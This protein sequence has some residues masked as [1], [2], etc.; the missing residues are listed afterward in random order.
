MVHYQTECM[1]TVNKTEVDK[2]GLGD[3]EKNK[4]Q[5]VFD[6]LVLSQNTYNIQNL[7]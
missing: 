3:M 2:V 6:P 4:H 7:T 5:D 1:N